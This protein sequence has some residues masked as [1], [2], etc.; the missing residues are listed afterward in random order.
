MNAIIHVKDDN[1]NLQSIQ[2]NTTIANV[3]GLQSALDGKVSTV[4]VGA[5]E[6]A[7]DANGKVTLPT[8]PTTLPAS[9]VYS[10][11]KASSKP[12]YTQDEVA[13]GSTYKKVTSTEKNT[14][15]NK[16]TYS[17]PSG[18]IPKSDLASSIQTSLGKADTALQSFTETDPTVPS[19]AKASSKPSY[20]SDEISDTNR[21]HKFATA[22]QLQQIETNKTTIAEIVDNGEKNILNMSRYNVPYVHNQVTF[23]I[24]SDGALVCNGT[25]NG[26]AILTLAQVGFLDVSDKVVYMK[27]NENSGLNS[28]F[29]D[30]YDAGWTN[31]EKCQSG[32][33]VV[34]K[35]TKSTT[36]IWRLIIPS[37]KQ[38]NN[39]KIY[40]MLCSKADFAISDAYVKPF[41]FYTKERLSNQCISDNLTTFNFDIT[42]YNTSAKDRFRYGL[43]VG[44]TSA[45]NPLLFHVFINTSNQVTLTKILGES[46][47]TASITDT[48]L[49]ITGNATVYGGL[50]LI[51]LD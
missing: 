46:T 32:T 29:F 2:P 10:W 43:L 4:N 37:G 30:I 19:W 9:D 48:T 45:G 16:G 3:T 49:S 36:G 34:Y 11:A 20:N 5:A 50:R 38:C 31:R 13:D 24:D 33:K 22:A 17:K 47:F 39:L 18:G 23:T 26:D 27:S 25:A 15:N 7:P 44:G 42:P 35:E 21:T 12:S 28:W 40:P 1:G 6:Y 41:M 14:W 51:W 8:Y